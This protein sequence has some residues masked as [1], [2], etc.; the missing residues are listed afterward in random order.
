MPQGQV[1]LIKTGILCIPTYDEAAVQAVRRVLAQS[2]VAFVLL[3]EQVVPMQ[4][5]VV[6]D[7]AAPLV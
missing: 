5:Y 3:A 7:Q 2:D 6:E 4:R 1:H